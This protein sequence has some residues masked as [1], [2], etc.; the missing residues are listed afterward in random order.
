MN[1]IKSILLM[2]GLFAM[3]FLQAQPLNKTDRKSVV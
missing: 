1:F 2:L 3:P